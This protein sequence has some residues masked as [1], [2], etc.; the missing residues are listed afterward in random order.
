MIKHRVISSPST[1][2]D[3]SVVFN[4]IM[5]DV[6]EGVL[7]YRTVEV[8]APA[9]T[10]D[11]DAY[12]TDN[13]ATL[14]ADEAAQAATIGDWINAEKAPLAGYYLAVLVAGY[15]ALMAGESV[16]VATGAAVLAI[17]QNPDQEAEYKLVRDAMLAAS[18]DDLRR[19]LAA[20]VFAMSGVLAGL[21]SR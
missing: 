18:D 2:G 10:V 7:Q 14:W 20:A 13:F 5:R 4:I 6:V 8:I 12:V 19:L 17:Q 15:S 9:G 16:S 1:L 11:L 3:A 21:R